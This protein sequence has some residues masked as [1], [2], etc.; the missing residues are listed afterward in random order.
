MKD[1]QKIKQKP[2]G[3]ILSIIIVTALLIAA[4]SAPCMP[5]LNSKRLRSKLKK[6]AMIMLKII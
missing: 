4:A 3:R 6:L 2:R 1:I 5:T